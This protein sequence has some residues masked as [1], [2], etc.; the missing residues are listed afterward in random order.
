VLRLLQA[1]PELTPREREIAHLAAHG[2]SSKQI[3]AQLVISVRTVDN[4]LH[5]V[6]NKLGINR[7]ADLAPILGAPAGHLSNIET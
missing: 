4:A 3:A 5:E 2:H 6:Y 1:P 7:C